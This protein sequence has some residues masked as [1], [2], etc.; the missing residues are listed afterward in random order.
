MNARRSIE[1]K[2]EITGTD[3]YEN[4][5]IEIDEGGIFHVICE[6]AEKRENLISL[7]GGMQKN[8][9]ICILDGVDTREQLN[10]Y[11]KK[12]DVVDIDKVDSTLTVK[13]YIVF[14]AM[15]TGIYSDKTIDKLTEL[16]TQNEMENVLDTPVNEL[17]NIEKV[18]VR[19]LAAYMKHISCLIGKGLLDGLN[20]IQKEVFFTFLE[21]YFMKEHCLCLLFDSRHHKEDKI[22]RILI[23]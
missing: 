12:I 22:N 8:G 21:Q 19:C 10:E 6:D 2:L 17:S 5:Q 15:V 14:Y 23:D 13:N 20:P 1:I 16:L 11:K 18:I 7:I 3:T 9:G 4:C